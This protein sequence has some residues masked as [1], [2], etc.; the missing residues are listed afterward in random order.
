[1]GAAVVGGGSSYGRVASWSN[2]GGDDG[3]NSKRRG[4]SLGEYSRVRER[5]AS[6]LDR[7]ESNVTSGGGNVTSGDSNTVS[8]VEGIETSAGSIRRPGGGGGNPGGPL[9]LA[10]AAAGEPVVDV[11][12]FK[13]L[14]D[15]SKCRSPRV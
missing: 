6:G 14:L 5:S 15:R 4:A 8:K 1:M 11:E 12:S 2:D 9:P 3:D 13:R 7:A 10:V